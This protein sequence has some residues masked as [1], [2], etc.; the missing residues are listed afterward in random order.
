MTR[1]GAIAA[2]G[3]TTVALAAAGSPAPSP[4]FGPRLASV[5]PEVSSNW[6]GYAAVAPVG[7]SVSFADVTGTWVEPRASCT[8][9]RADGVAFWVGLG[10][11]AESSQSLEQLGTAAECDG[12]DRAARHYVWWEIVPAAVV[13]LKMK[14]EPGD[15]VTAAVLVKGK[16]VT[17][18][19][20]NL[21]RG[22]RFSRTA[23][24]P[25]ELD[26]SSA[27]WIAEAPASCSAR[28]HCRVIP[29]TN[30]GRVTFTQAAAIGNDRPGTI[31]D[32]TW[33]ATPI[34]LITG[35]GDGRFF[36]RGDVLG[37]GVG[38]VPGDL[39]A[40]GRSFTVTWAQDL[41]PPGE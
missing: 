9:G 41:T 3:L 8:G 2:A 1:L 40:D 37:P 21:T 23:T 35:G 30:F 29:L 6:S 25:Q 5:T 4:A 19:L 24:V 10:G 20:K 14:L 12:S 34:E 33:A 17:M 16:K 11:Y 7:G 39:S 15:R 31:S 32:P 27:E 28:G 13:E 38:A 22:T 18:S 26:V 36:G